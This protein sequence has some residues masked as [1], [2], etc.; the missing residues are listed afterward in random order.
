MKLRFLTD[1]VV[2]FLSCQ[3]SRDSKVDDDATVTVSL[4]RRCVVVFWAVN[5]SRTPQ[6]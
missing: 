4:T 6:R 1:E 2:G 5:E 3:D